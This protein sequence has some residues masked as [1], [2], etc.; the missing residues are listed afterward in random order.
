MHAT[1]M[2]TPGLVAPVVPPSPITPLVTPVAPTRPVHAQ[3]AYRRAPPPRYPV[4]ARR[5]GMQ[6]TVT[7]RVLVDT[8]G[9]P[10]DVVVVHGSG[11]P[12]LDRAARR[13]VLADWRFEPARVNGRRVPAWAL[14][15]VVFQ[16]RQP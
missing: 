5:A 7:L 4:P 3:L 2:S 10:Q 8:R 14:V 1:P 6:G 9:K 13:K 15:P 12:L 16:L 11:H